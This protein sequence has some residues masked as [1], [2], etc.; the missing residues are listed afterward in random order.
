MYIQVGAI[1][2]DK[3]NCWGGS[4][5]IGHPFAAT[6]CRLVTMAANRLIKEN[7]KYALVAACAAGGQVTC[8]TW[9]SHVNVLTCRPVELLWSD[10]HHSIT[11]NNSIMSCSHT[12]WLMLYRYC[13]EFTYMR[14]YCIFI[15][16]LKPSYLSSVLILASGSL[17]A[18]DKYFQLCR[19][20]RIVTSQLYR[21]MTFYC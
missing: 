8:I 21:V 7:G 17:I 4:L 13:L 11:Q 9:W 6:G 1:P 14:V 18:H 20:Q 10:I 12:N 3:L 2:I 16:Y 5:S 15:S 19:H